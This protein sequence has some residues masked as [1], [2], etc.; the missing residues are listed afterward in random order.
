MDIGTDRHESC[1][2]KLGLTN[3]NEILREVHIRNA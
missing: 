1:L 2:V 3:V